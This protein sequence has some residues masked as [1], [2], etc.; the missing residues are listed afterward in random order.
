[1]LV[2]INQQLLC[3]RISNKG[4]WIE[5]THNIARR[6]N[7]QRSATVRDIVYQKNQN[8]KLV[9]VQL[10]QFL[11]LHMNFV[12]LLKY[13]STMHSVLKIS[14]V[15][16]HR[17][18]RDNYDWTILINWNRLRSNVVLYHLHCRWLLLRNH[19]QDPKKQN[20]RRERA[21]KGGEEV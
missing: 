2:H 16:V 14:N 15:I 20:Q 10:F 11:P 6:S 17:I 19:I 8:H 12:H 1:M 4:T 3:S 9:N 7:D 18:R 13:L 21:V 5:L